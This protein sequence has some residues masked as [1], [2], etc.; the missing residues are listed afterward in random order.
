MGI[1]L[2]LFCS[3][4]NKS[5]FSDAQYSKNDFKKCFF[6]ISNLFSKYV[7]LS[8]YNHICFLEKKYKTFQLFINYFSIDIWNNK[9]YFSFKDFKINIYGK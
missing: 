1:F 6:R 4:I 8:I 3:N 5:R 7:I 9:L 2:L